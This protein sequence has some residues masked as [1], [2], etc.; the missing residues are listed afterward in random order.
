MSI[1]RF[2]SRVD[3]A[4]SP[5]LSDPADLHS[6][7]ATKTVCLEAP[8]D[9]EKHPIHI[10]GFLFATNLCARIYPRLRILAPSRIADECSAVARR[11]NPGCEIEHGPGRAAARLCWTGDTS[12]EDSITVSP[13]GWDVLIDPLHADGLRATNILTSLAAGAIG[14]SEVFRQVFTA[15]LPSGRGTR[16]PGGFNLLTLA[17][18]DQN[19]PDLPHSIDVGRVHLVGAGAIG[20]A[21]VYALA[22]VQVR[23]TLVVLDP[24]VVSISNLQRYVLANDAD[25]GASKISLVERALKGTGIQTIT[26][27]VPWGLESLESEQPETICAA[28][29]T[30]ALRIAIQASLPKRAYNAWTQPADIGWSRHESFGEDACLACLYWPTRPRPSYDE[31]IA[32]ALKEH[33]LRALAY[34]MFNVPVDAVLLPEQIPRLAPLPAPPDA[35]Q[36]TERSLLQDVALRFGLKDD[37][38][39]AWQGRQLSDLYHEGICAGALIRH[40]SGE[41]SEEVAVPLAHQSALAG[42]MLAAQLLIAATPEL[43]AHRPKAIEARLNLLARFPQLSARPRMRT[44]NCICSDAVFLRQ[45]SVKWAGASQDAALS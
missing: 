33:Q 20:Q 32:R 42:I 16:N 22:A 9:V 1:P 23:G 43:A 24:E 26:K 3:D 37:D 36:W 44:A 31:L 29:D 14:A 30:A 10:A 8:D 18:P 25:V 19:L 2:F 15:Y 5:L 35:P 34:L 12:S 40:Q 11:I 45:Y 17:S 27:Q 39:K 7:L 41:L 38:I 28:V 4:I 21:M 13:A 6:F